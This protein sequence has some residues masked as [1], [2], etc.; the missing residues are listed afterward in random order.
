VAFINRFLASYL[1]KFCLTFA[2]TRL[3]FALPVKHLRQTDN[4][5]A[6]HHPKPEYPLHILLLPKKVI[7]NLMDVTPA[8]EPFLT[9][10]YM[11][12]Q[13]L[14]EEF[15]LQREGYRLI[16]NGGTYQKFPH[17]HFHLISGSPLKD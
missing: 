1:G 12:V 4:L 16:V 3:S 9:D 14:V 17:L 15:G 2:F 8:D 10:L 7:E 11:T 13:I 6:F 5:I